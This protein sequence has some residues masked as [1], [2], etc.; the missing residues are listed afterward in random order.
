MPR[1][2][3]GEQ[4]RLSA[5]AHDTDGGVEGRTRRTRIKGQRAGIGASGEEKIIKR[6]AA[7]QKHA[8]LNPLSQF[9]R[10]G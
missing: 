8:V 4:R 2:H 3:A 6:F 10:R 7:D 1:R 9:L 5:L